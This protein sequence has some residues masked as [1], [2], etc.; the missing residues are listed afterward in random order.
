MWVPLGYCPK[1]CQSREQ[2]SKDITTENL[3]LGVDGLKAKKNTEVAQ[4]W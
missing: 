1:A 3:P 4:M 2:K